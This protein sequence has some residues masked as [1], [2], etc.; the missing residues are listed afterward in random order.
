LLS[1]QAPFETLNPDAAVGEVDVLPSEAAE[2]GDAQPM[3]EGEHEH[4]GIAPVIART[5]CPPE[6]QRKFLFTEIVPRALM[7]IHGR[8][9]WRTFD[10]TP[11]GRDSS[12][13]PAMLR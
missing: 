3:I 11:H 8:R 6:E 1:G 12:P 5:R 10:L 9:L 7:G 4:G 2:F 13:V